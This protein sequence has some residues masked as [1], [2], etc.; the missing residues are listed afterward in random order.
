MP[1]IFKLKCQYC[2]NIFEAKA[3][4]VKYCD[5]CYED[6]KCSN[7]EC[8]NI[9]HNIFKGDDGNHFCS[10]SCRYKHITYI[11][12]QPG[13]CIKCGNWSEHRDSTGRCGNCVSQQVKTIDLFNRIYKNIM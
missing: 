8:N 7:I 4:N 10:K 1:R 3:S 2:G 11:K 6:R 9:I 13:Y 12:T 5:N